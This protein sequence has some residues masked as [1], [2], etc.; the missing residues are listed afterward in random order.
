[1]VQLQDVG[2]QQKGVREDVVEE[3]S[4]TGGPGHGVPLSAKL[5]KPKKNPE[6]PNAAKNNH[7]RLE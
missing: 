5:K 4:R 3:R 1:M 6:N 7:R 2:G